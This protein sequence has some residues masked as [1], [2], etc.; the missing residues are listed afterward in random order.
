MDDED[1]I[2]NEKLETLNRDSIAFEKTREKLFE[3]PASRP[4][5][6]LESEIQ[7][8][9]D[10]NKKLQFENNNLKSDIFV[11]KEELHTLKTKKQLFP[12]EL[13]RPASSITS[14]PK[15]M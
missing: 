8:L 7:C 5:F 9:K 14:T 12:E 1:I 13:K 2:I 11:L 4:N 3:I 6:A 15:K 10:E